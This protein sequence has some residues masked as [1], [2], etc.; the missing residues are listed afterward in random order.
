MGRISQVIKAVLL[1]MSNL[2][3]WVLDVSVL[4]VRLKKAVVKKIDGG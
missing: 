3:L 2:C 4:D 1:T